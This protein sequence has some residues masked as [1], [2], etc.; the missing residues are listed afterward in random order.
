MVTRFLD[1]SKSHRK[2]DDNGFLIITQNP[3]AKSGVFEYLKSEILPNFKGDDGLVKV[4]RPFEALKKAKDSFA[5]KPIK[6]THKW[7]GDEANTADGAISSE[8]KADEANGYLIAD[9]IIYNPELIAKIE[10]GEVVELSPAYTGEVLANSG[11]YDGEDYEFT[12]SVDCVNHL[13][14]VESGRSGSDLRILD[15]KP[16][17]KDEKMNLSKFK[18]ELAKLVTKF[19]DEQGEEE[20]PVVAED[21]DVAS[22]LLEIAKSELDDAEK[23]AKINELLAVKDESCVDEG[24]KVAEDSEP[25]AEGDEPVAE[26]SIDEG[27]NDESQVEAKIAEIVNEAID[28]KLSAFQDSLKSE[29][30]K[31]QDSYAEVSKALGSQFDYSN[32]SASEIYKLGYELLSGKTLGEGVDAKSA[33]SVISQM[34]TP[35]FA[36]A[37]PQTQSTSKILAMLEKM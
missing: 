2:K 35:K 26:D 19:K 3:I 29:A 6:L 12:Q 25:V 16:K 27:E 10:S 36:D 32:K 11:R 31:I 33:F 14:V 37:K 24:E 9:L 8:I 21:S 13:A 15:E 30:K 23:I 4:Y 20:T 5:N 17:R 22:K 18:D 28:K 7:V 34:R 1:I